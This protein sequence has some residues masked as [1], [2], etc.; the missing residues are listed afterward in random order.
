MVKQP[1][2]NKGTRYQYPKADRHKNGGLWVEQGA[3]LVTLVMWGT[4]HVLKRTVTLGEALDYADGIVVRAR[5]TDKCFMCGVKPSE[6]EW[7]HLY[8]RTDS[9]LLPLGVPEADLLVW[10]CNS[11]DPLEVRA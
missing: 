10:A 5:P 11:C 2:A 1:N 6:S 3:G 9:G 8:G 7:L 4:D